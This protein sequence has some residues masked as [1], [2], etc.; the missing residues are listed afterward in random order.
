MTEDGQLVVTD[1]EEMMVTEE[2]P[3][4]QSAGVRLVAEHRRGPRLLVTE[5]FG[6]QELVM[7]EESQAIVVTEQG[8]RLTVVPG[9]IV[10]TDGRTGLVVRGDARG[11][12]ENE[13]EN[14]DVDV[15]EDLESQR[16]S[17]GTVLVHFNRQ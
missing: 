1:Q 4:D 14:N 16:P 9:Q 8:E 11:G 12:E 7:T 6:N 3:G 13:E 17:N 5:E 2:V 10:V 15:K